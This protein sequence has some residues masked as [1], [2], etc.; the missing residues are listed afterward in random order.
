MSCD[1]NVVQECVSNAIYDESK[2][3]LNGALS[4]AVVCLDCCVKFHVT[5]MVGSKTESGK[6]SLI[7]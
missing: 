5:F 4:R 1:S 6:I 7:F 3:N 2:T